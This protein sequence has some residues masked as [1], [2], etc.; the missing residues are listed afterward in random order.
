MNREFLKEL[1]LEDEAIEKIMKEH[2][3]STNA[4][5]DKADK[6]DGL[7][8]QITDLQGQIQERDT[9]LDTLSKQVKD[10]DELTNTIH[11]LKDDNKTA[12]EELQQKLEKQALEFTLEKALGKAGA[13]NPKAVKALLNTESIKLDGETLLGLDDQLKALQESDAYLFGEDEPGGLKGRKPHE[14]G[15]P[16]PTNKNPFSKDHFNLTEQGR[17]L[18][19]NPELYKQLKA[20][21]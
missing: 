2:G 16:A 10:N 5:K 14:G 17:L 13:K 12:T 4:I 21:A 11:Q 20:Q 7:E 18:R 19:D 6:V 8:S 9:Q 3:K 1:G 15:N